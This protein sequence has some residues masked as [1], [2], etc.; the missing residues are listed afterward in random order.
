MKRYTLQDLKQDA[1]KRKR[2][3]LNT[4]KSRY[5]LARSLGFTSQEA[6][7]L[8]NRRE[9]IIRELAEERNDGKDKVSKT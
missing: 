8:Q 9:Y 2:R 4:L 1:D 6:V 5:A 7:I 3:H